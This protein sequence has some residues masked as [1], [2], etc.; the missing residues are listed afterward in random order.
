[1]RQAL[2]FFKITSLTFAFT[3]AVEN[4]EHAARADATESAITARLI[5]GELEKVAR[6]IDHGGR[7]V[8]HYQSARAHNCSNLTQ[9]LKIDRGIRQSR[10]DAATGRTA[11]LNSFKPTAWLHAAANFLDDLAN[12]CAHGY[13]DE[14]AALNVFG[15]GENFCAFA[16]F[17]SVSRESLWAVTNEP[18]NHSECL[19]VV[20]DRRF[21]PK[22]VLDRKRGAQ[23]RHAALAF[24]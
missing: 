9:R 22:A 13:L 2:E 16:G 12:G 3:E 18:R 1:M 15:Q 10:W 7:I 20:D 6:D 5:L 4:I 23:F 21:S 11:D 19:D 17:G 8:Q 24:D 14:P